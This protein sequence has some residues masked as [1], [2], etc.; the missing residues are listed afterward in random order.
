M[1]IFGIR[2]NYLAIGGVENSIRNL[3]NVCIK[4][5]IAVTLVCREPLQ[6]EQM[7]VDQSHAPENINLVYYQDEFYSHRLDRLLYFF[8]GGRGLTKLYQELYLKHPKAAVIVRNHSHGIAANAA[9][10]RAVRYL[11]PSVVANQLSQELNALDLTDRLLMRLKICMDG[12]LQTLSFHALEL[13]VFSES[14]RHQIRK[15]MMIHHRE[16]QINLVK[17]G[18]DSERFN[19]PTPT[20]SASLRKKLDL[21]IDKKLLLFT[22][23]FVQAKGLVYAIE[24]LSFLPEDFRL[25]LVG[26]GKERQ[27]LEHVIQKNGLQKRILFRRASA[28]VENYYRSCDLFIMSS[29]YEPLGQSVIEAAASGLPIVAFHKQTGVDTAAHEMEFNGVM[30]YAMELSARAL[31]SAIE[32]A[33]SEINEKTKAIT[34]SELK[35]LYSWDTLLDSLCR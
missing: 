28:R 35:T 7:E 14:M 22:G 11:V 23:R 29:L 18:V 4:R 21:P 10:F 31:A 8:K 15:R 6:G 27:N 26:E 3:V 5:G 16:K 34:V 24:A 9:G 13:F 25:V 12:Y 19:K 33:L 2:G 30:F 17:P 1:L 32:K 20:E